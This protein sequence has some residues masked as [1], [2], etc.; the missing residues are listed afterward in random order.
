MLILLEHY[1]LVLSPFFISRLLKDEQLTL[2]DAN[3]IKHLTKSASKLE[4]NLFHGYRDGVELVRLPSSVARFSKTIKLEE[5]DILTAKFEARVP[6]E[7]PRKKMFLTLP[8]GH[9]R[10][11]P[12]KSVFAVIYRADVLAEDG[13]Q[14]DGDWAIVALITSTDF[15]PEPMEPETLLA[16]H[17][18]LSGGT[19]TNWTSVEFEDRLHEAVNY[20]KNKALLYVETPIVE[21]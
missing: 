15:Y 12:A 11:I 7:E 17:Y 3:E 14:I 10:I 5:G 20:W 2:E 1:K 21:P 8:L 9:P 18:H 16:N 19:R 6:G 13:E 4:G